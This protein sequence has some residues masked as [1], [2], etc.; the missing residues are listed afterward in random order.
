[1]RRGA[2]GVL[3]LVLALGCEGEPEGGDESS[4]SGSDSG[5]LAPCDEQPVITYDTFGR[6]FFATYCD[7]CHGSAVVERQGA[8]MDVTFDT[9]D[10]AL[11][12]VDRILARTAPADDSEPTMPPV[13]GVT[14]ADR[15]RLVV[16]LTCWE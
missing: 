9:R 16:W 6:G 7:G 12:Q 11:S 4:G 5:E 3:W 13:G 15:E 8:P 10:A 1:M 14:D 2:P